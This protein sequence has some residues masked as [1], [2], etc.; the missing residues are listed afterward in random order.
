MRM[1]FDPLQCK[2][3]KMLTTRLCFCVPVC[4]VFIALFVWIPPAISETATI[5]FSFPV[6]SPADVGIVAGD[7][8]R[9]SGASSFHPLQQVSGPASDT[10]VNGGFTSTNSDF[11]VKFELPGTYYYRC[12]NHGVAASGGTMRGSV[13]VQALAGST[14]IADP[15]ET[16][17][18]CEA[19][20]VAPELSSPAKNEITRK[21]RVA[22]DWA[23]T[24]CAATYKVVVRA[25][26]KSGKIVDQKPLG[27]STYRT[28]RLKKG[29]SY[30]WSVK[31]CNSFGCGPSS[32]SNFVLK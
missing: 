10:P 12:M 16:P 21:A 14:P 26:K 4:L 25:D 20:P 8:V 7:S 24:L 30:F 15:T 1:A 31:A 2:N 22:M 32:S 5:N 13:L 29:R 11:V 19:K 3:Y 17:S 23:D 9:W 6:P 18:E 28:I 27:I